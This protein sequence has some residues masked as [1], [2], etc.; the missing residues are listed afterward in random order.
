MWRAYPAECIAIESS[1]GRLADAARHDRTITISDVRYADF[2]TDPIEQGHREYLLFMKRKSFAHEQE[3]RACVFLGDGTGGALLPYDLEKLI[4]QI[5][6]SPR[7]SK[8]FADAI[9][10]ISSGAIP[11]LNKPVLPSRLYEKPDYN[12]D[13][14]PD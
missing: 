13:L 7:G 5:H 3:L 1:V 2:D 4:A 6:I 14:K 8:A 9:T 11:A 12:I 10:A